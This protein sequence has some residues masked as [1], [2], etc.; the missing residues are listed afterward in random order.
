MKP[1]GLIADVGPESTIDYDRA[2]VHAKAVV[3]QAPR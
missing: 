3:E 1:I 2:I